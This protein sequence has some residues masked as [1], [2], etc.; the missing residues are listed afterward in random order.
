MG[1]PRWL[2]GKESTCNAGNL[3]SIPGSGRPLEEGNN[4]PFQYSYLGNP[5]GRGVCGLTAHEVDNSDM[6]EHAEQHLTA[7]F[8]LD[9][10]PIY[11]RG[12]WGLPLRLG[13][14]TCL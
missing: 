13:E 9:M 12:K 1:L 3:G 8:E 11:R 2:S 14:S 4:F 10:H 7:T 6:T 5:V